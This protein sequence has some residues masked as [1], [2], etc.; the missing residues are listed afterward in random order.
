MNK[1]I[2]I[3]MIVLIAILALF[4]A[5]LTGYVLA[6]KGHEVENI[7]NNEVIDKSEPLSGEK[8]AIFNKLFQYGKEIYDKELYL[9][10]NK[11]VNDV[12][13][14]SVNDLDNLGYD[15]SIVDSNCNENSPII[16]FDVNFKFVNEYQDIPLMISLDCDN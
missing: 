16:F 9:S 1:N 6:V 12:Y 3:M 13:Y 15:I 14:A 11:D 2:K 10:F 4:G 8:E 7:K 5:G